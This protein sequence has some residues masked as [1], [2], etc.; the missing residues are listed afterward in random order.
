MRNLIL[1][2]LLFSSTC[3]YSQDSLNLKID[4]GPDDKQL[5]D[6]MRFIGI[7]QMQLNIS[8]KDLKGKKIVLSFEEFK[9]GKVI[10]KGNMTKGLPDM[11]L[12][13]TSDTFSIKVMSRATGDSAK[14]DFFYPRFNSSTE[15]YI[16]QPAKDYSMRFAMLANRDHT[17]RTAVTRERQAMFVYSLPYQKPNEDYKYYCALTAGGVPPEKWWDEYHVR[18]Y[19][20]FYL[21]IT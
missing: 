14:I 15:Y 19:I 10:N 8:H 20:I 16:E 18:H 4:Y 21:Q 9:E 1:A 12:Q 3:G 6:I 17:L 11:L 7:E 5:G 2:I 13:A